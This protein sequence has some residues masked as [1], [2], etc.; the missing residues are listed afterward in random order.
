MMKD[1]VEIVDDST[2]LQERHTLYV[3]GSPMVAVK[4]EHG[5]VRL[6]WMVHGPQS[7][8]PQGRALVIGLLE[9][10]VVADKLYNNLTK[11]P[12]EPAS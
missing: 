10:S 1:A 7:W 5:E 4:V 12:R 11:F 9:L 8:E 3:N 2:A 6:Q